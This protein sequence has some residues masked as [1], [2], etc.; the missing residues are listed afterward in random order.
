MKL[1]QS[2]AARA[3]MSSCL[4]VLVFVVTV[5]AAAAWLLTGILYRERKGQINAN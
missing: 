1:K 3:T 4:T 5:A 2:G